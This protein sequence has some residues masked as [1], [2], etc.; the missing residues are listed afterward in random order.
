[1]NVRVK[2]NVRIVLT[3]LMVM[4]FLFAS[5]GVSA[6][7]VYAQ[8]IPT[9]PTQAPAST[10][11]PVPQP[12]QEP[13]QSLSA[14][15]TPLNRL[16]PSQLQAVTKAPAEGTHPAPEVTDTPGEE[17]TQTPAVTETPAAPVAPAVTQTVP[18][19]PQVK[20]STV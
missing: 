1:M 20:Q 10:D 15:D 16:E 7:V 18:V 8:D 17:P 11:T 19:G 6:S 2:F 5:L 4:A 13:T 3:S 9:E 12:T 14:T